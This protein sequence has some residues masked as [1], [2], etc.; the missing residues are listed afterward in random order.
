VRLARRARALLVCAAV[1][2]SLGGRLAAQAPTRVPGTQI[3][4]APPPGFTPASTFAGFQHSESGASLMVLDL[5]GPVDEVLSGFEPAALGR[6]GM[7]LLSRE[8]LEDE[9]ALLHIEQR[10]GEALVHKWL[11]VF[12][13]GARTIFVMSVYPEGLPEHRVQTLRA[14]VV[15]ARWDPDIAVGPFEGLGFSLGESE[16]L[17]F[18][19]KAGTSVVFTEDG[20]GDLDGEGKASFSFGPALAP[21]EGDAQD[22]ARSRLAAVPGYGNLEVQHLGAIEVDGLSGYEIVASAESETGDPA[23][24]YEVMLF[25]GAT[26]WLG[27]GTV[28]AAASEAY[29]PVFE[30]LARSFRRERIAHESA[31]SIARVTTPASWSPLALSEAADLGLGNA[32]GELYFMVLT[33]ARSELGGMSLQEHSDLTRGSLVSGL[34][35]AREVGPEALEVGGRPALHYEIRGAMGDLELVYLH[36]TVDGPEHFHQLLAWTLASAIDSARA[37]FR[38][39]TASFEEL[40]E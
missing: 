34:E 38:A 6:Q 18:F 11:R 40:R 32:T 2:I 8:S 29:L 33:E 12:G 37:D 22:F 15:Q 5:A 30:S 17:E 26:Y 39:V 1:S 28:R 35:A 21:F 36:T 24:L 14:T 9:S 31:G 3:V 16:H 10:A 19:T 25:E 7:T 4:L 27:V 13:D 23:R 20:A